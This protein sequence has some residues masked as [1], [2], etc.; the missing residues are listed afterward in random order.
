MANIPPIY[1]FRTQRTRRLRSISRRP[2]HPKNKSNEPFPASLP[3]VRLVVVV[4]GPS[5]RG[6]YKVNRD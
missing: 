3:W 5:R 6:P 2:T 1:R 4:G